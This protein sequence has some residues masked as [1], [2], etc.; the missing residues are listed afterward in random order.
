MT[1][2][3]WHIFIFSALFVFLVLMA[4]RI[5]SIVRLPVHLRWELAPIPYEKEKYSYGGSYLEEFEWWRKKRSKSLLRVIIYMAGEIFLLKGIWKN[6]RGLWP[7][8]FALHTGIYLVIVS[9]VFHVINAI[10]I[11]TGVP[12]AV[13]DVFK[14]IAAVVGI[15]GYILGSLGAVGLILKRSLDANYKAFSSFSVYFKLVFLAAVFISG[16]IA[17]ATST[18]FATGMSLFTRDFFKLDSNITATIP[19]ASHLIISLL[20]L[21]YLPLTDM[22]HFITKYFTYHSVRW[23]DEPKDEKMIATLNSLMSQPV[24]WSADHIGA[25]GRKNWV[26]LTTKKTDDDKKP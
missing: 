26:E 15:I 12:S 17:W 3:F 2:F 13:L 11:I 6:N 5:L 16:I 19:I 20:F 21:I 4:Y 1:G 8:S 24:Y 10:F 14:G 22:A 18:D 7:F 25:D 9:I 23:D